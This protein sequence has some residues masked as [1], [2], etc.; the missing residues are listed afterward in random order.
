M[1]FYLQV[2]D[3]D[4][5]DKDDMMGEAIIPLGFDFDEKDIYTAWY[6]LQEEVNYTNYG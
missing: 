6:S 1:Y 2:L 3:S 4:M 5:M